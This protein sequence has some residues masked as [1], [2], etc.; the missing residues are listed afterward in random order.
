VL[1]P[2]VASRGL[3]DQEIDLEPDALRHP[4]AVNR[5]AAHEVLDQLT[6]NLAPTLADDIDQVRVQIIALSSTIVRYRSPSC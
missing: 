3:R 5:V 2:L 6:L 1:S 4:G